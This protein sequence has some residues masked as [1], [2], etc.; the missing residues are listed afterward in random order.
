MPG[1]FMPLDK[2]AD[3]QAKHYAQFFQTALSITPL[4]KGVLE[5][6]EKAHFDPQQDSQV[7]IK[8]LYNY[9]QKQHPEAGAAYW[10]TRGWTM[11]IWQPLYLAFIGVYATHAVPKLSLVGQYWGENGL[12]AGFT[13]PE[14]RLFTGDL[15]ELIDYSGQELKLL[16]S[17]L[18]E[19]FSQQY[20]L[21]PGFVAH[22]LADSILINLTE[23]QQVRTDL[24]VYKQAELWF[25]ALDLPN[26]HL[27]ALYKVPKAEVWSVKRISCCMHYR[28]DDGD[29]CSNCPKN[30]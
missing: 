7:A 27:N 11:L 24:D 1:Q 29:L 5:K 25:V 6:P 8:K 16:F 18:R 10:L 17:S 3:M 20:R 9:W 15:W 28:R 23:L 12:I 30:K 4:L 2:D 19:Q 13:L 26:K 22:L 14:R 21:R